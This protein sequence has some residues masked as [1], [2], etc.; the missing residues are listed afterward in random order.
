MGGVA[1]RAEAIPPFIV[2]DV[3]ERAQ[4][5][6]REGRDIVHLEVGEPCFDTPKPI[7][8]AGLRAMRSGKT[9]YTHSLGL[10]ELREAIA[11]HYCESYGV[12][13]SPS[14]IVVT[15]GTSPAMLLIFSA[16]LI[17]L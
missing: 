8:E 13:V 16:L 4:E 12:D 11:D 6:E 3:L 5:L 7:I 1:H 15:S 2:M 14:Q 10:L 17:L 9:H